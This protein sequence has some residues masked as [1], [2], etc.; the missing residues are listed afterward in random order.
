MSTP[1]PATLALALLD[2]SSLSSLNPAVAHCLSAYKQAFKAARDRGKG[3]VFSEL[4][5]EEAYRLAMPTLSGGD[6]IRD[7]IACTA[8]GMIIGAFDGPTG[9]RL[10]YAARVARSALRDQP[11]PRKPVTL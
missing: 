7:F 4:D 10:L 6:S 3:K 2:P 8:Q 9:A 11:K 1:T 5:G